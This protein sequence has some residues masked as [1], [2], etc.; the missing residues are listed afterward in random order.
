MSVTCPSYHV[1][2]PEEQAAVSAA[3][4]E[5][6]PEP[7][8]IFRRSETIIANRIDTLNVKDSPLLLASKIAA[9]ILG[10]GKE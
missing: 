1:R 8:F 10:I 6:Y 2:S 4:S 9:Q 5:A 3:D 7:L